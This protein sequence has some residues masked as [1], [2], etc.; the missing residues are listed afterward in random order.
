V[1]SSHHIHPQAICEA[2]QIGSGTSVH[3]FALVA[4]DCVVGD[5]CT[6]GGGAQILAGARLGRGAVIGENAVVQ[7]GVVVSRGSVIEAGSVVADPVPANAIVRGN[8]AQIIG[9]VGGDDRL[10][11]SPRV[12]RV[13]RLGEQ[14]TRIRNAGIH[15]LTRADDL[16]GSLM[17]ADFAGLPFTPVRVFTVSDVPSEHIRGSH[18]H[19]ECAQLLVCVR[20]SINVVLDDG[21]TREEFLLGNAE[22]GLHVPPMTWSTQYKYSF[23]ATLLVLASHPYD[24]ADYIRDYDEFLELVEKSG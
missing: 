22:F 1:S 7:P 15:S 16:R 9:Y 21:A 13:A 23:D 6:I 17:A 20:G 10:I 24:P 8:P 2:T 14:P 12:E 18:A 4:A 11:I 19:L 5:D 3:A